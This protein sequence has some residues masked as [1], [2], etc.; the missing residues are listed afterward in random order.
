MN[1]LDQFLA[2]LHRLTM[3][4]PQHCLAGTHAAFLE[5]SRLRPF[6]VYG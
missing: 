1:K 2:P 5:V 6:L 3:A 4:T